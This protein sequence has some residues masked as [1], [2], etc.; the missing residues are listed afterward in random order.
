MSNSKTGK[1]PKLL[2]TPQHSALT[3]QSFLFY[4][5]ER[6]NSRKFVDLLSREM[7]GSASVRG[8][9]LPARRRVLCGTRRGMPREVAPRHPLAS[10]LRTQRGTISLHEQP[11][12]LAEHSSKLTYPF[13]SSASF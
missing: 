7:T 9:A 2:S 12:P 13:C 8:T 6:S 1:S 4:I 10:L 5:L 11:F 3:C